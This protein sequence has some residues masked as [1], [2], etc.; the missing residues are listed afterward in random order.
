M[1]TRARAGRSRRSGDRV[2]LAGGERRRKFQRLESRHD[3][4]YKR[5]VRHV[6][7][8][9]RH[10]HGSHR[11]RRRHLAE[12]QGARRR[13]GNPRRRRTRSTLERCTTQDELVDAGDE[14]DALGSRSGPGNDP[15]RPMARSSSPEASTR[16][17]HPSATADLDDPANNMFTPIGVHGN[18]PGSLSLWRRS[19]T[20]KVLAGGGPDSWSRHEPDP[21]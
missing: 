4:L 17:K 18:G 13:A 5:G 6:D 9:R 21:P 11:A 15:S 10:E 7:A 3:G 14:H 2:L 20:G 12:R 8:C 1:T 19:P 16:P